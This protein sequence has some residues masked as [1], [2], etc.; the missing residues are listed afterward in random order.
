MPTLRW[1]VAM[2]AAA[3][4]VP[5]QH[6]FTMFPSGRAGVALLCLRLAVVA[7][8]FSAVELTKPAP[9]G[10]TVLATVIGFALCIGLVTPICASICCVVAVYFLFNITGT[11]MLCV[12]VSA[13]IALV[14]ALLGPGAYSVDARLYGRRRVVFKQPENIRGRPRDD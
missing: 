9:I 13:L 2:A 7:T 8:I 11:A 3:Y 5:M 12:G 6:L 14:L 1:M 10:I 4:A